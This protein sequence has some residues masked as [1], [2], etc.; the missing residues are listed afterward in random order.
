MIWT[1]HTASEIP[2][3]PAIRKKVILF[4]SAGFHTSKV[5]IRATWRARAKAITGLLP[6]TFII[7]P[8]KMAAIPLQTPKHIITKPMLEI[9]HP[10][11]TKA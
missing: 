8:T 11:E 9:P 3:N 10:Q 4:P 6:V 5:T 7:P 2:H 1:S